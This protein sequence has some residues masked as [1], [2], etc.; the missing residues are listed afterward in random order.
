VDGCP[1][2]QNPDIDSPVRTATNYGCAFNSNLAAMVANP[3]DLVHGREASG[4]GAVVVAG[5]ALRAYRESQPTSR[6]GLPASNTTTEVGKE[7]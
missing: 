1:Y 7:T 3:D 4:D 5:R 6:Q 2:W